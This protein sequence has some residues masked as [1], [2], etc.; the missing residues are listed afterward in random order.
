MAAII[1]YADMK[2]STKNQ[3]TITTKLLMEFDNIAYVSGP[4]SQWVRLSYFSSKLQ[5]YI[6]KVSNGLKTSLAMFF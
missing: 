6:R 4:L 1:I 3:Q 2:V 5:K